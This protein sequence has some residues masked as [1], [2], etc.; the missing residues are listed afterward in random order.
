MVR[1][2]IALV[3]VSNNLK[4]VALSRFA[5]E[6][7]HTGSHEWK[8]VTRNKWFLICVKITASVKLWERNKLSINRKRKKAETDP[9]LQEYCYIMS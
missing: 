1:K 2:V 9:C 7:I 5:K 3:C 8:K 6:I 4:W